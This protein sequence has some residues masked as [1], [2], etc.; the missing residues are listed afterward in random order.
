MSTSG[1]Q[2]THEAAADTARW[3][4][5]A[6]DH[7]HLG[8]RGGHVGCCDNVSMEH[9]KHILDELRRCSSASVSPTSPRATGIAP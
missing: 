8:M 5:T 3:D 6:L 1:N 2:S 9:G 7:L 4:R